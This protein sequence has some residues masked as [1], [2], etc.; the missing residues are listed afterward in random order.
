MQ[1]TLRPTTQPAMQPATHLIDD[2]AGG[3]PAAWRF[4]TDSVMG[5]LSSGAITS[6]V[7][8]GRPALCL[9]GRVRLENNGGF[10]QMALDVVPPPGEWS[11]LE[12][13]LTGRAH[14]YGVH[15]RTTR[16][17]APWQAWRARVAVRP[18]WQT[19]R[20]PFSQF[21][22]Y[23][24]SGTLAAAEIRRIGLVALG[25]AFDAELCLARAAWV[26]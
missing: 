12:F 8:Q 15:L 16:L 19:L 22:P 5:G 18:E 3:E 24:F 4:F 20:V 2:R 11:A 1:P 7:V 23:R 14:D 21:A 6:E 17:S 10:I 26:R 9:R 25:E 13:D